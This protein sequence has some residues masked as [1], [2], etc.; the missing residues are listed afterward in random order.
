MLDRDEIGGAGIDVY[1]VEPLENDHPLR[2]S[3]N[4][5]LTSHTAWNSTQS[6]PTLQRLAAEEAV[7]A[8]RGEPLKNQISC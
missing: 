7:R 1:E 8:L 4:T 5:I 2:K 3:K 6:V